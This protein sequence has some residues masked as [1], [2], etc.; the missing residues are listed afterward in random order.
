MDFSKSRE[1]GFTLIELMTVILILSILAATAIPI[2]SRSR[3]AAWK[4]SCS[5]NL[6]ILDGNILI[7]KAQNGSIPDV[8]NFSW[9]KDSNF[10]NTLVDP[11][12]DTDD[13]V[14]YYVKEPIFCP[15]GGIYT[16]N[17]SVPLTSKFCS[18]SYPEHNEY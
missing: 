4:S 2:Y 16:Y 18:C 15:R 14:P 11:D 9:S 7:Y 17:P 10:S 12:D 6:R 3:D 5:A 13:L 1:S 8:S